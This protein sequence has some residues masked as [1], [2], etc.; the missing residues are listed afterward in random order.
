MRRFL[1]SLALCLVLATFGDASGSDR[2]VADAVSALRA[3][4]ATISDNRNWNGD[5]PDEG[6]RF[7]IF[8]P[9]PSAGASLEQA[10]DLLM[11]PGLQE[12]LYAIAV[13]AGTRTTLDIR[14][15]RAF[16][17]LE[18]LSISYTSVA[19]PED[20]SQLPNL[21][22]LRF[23]D[24]ADLDLAVVARA[25]QVTK[26]ELARMRIA[27]LAPL[28][29]MSG[30]RS[31]ELWSGQL[32]DW[33]SLGSLTQ[34]TALKLFMTGGNLDVL[35]GLRRLRSLELDTVYVGQSGALFRLPLERLS[36]HDSLAP[37]L[38]AILDM[39]TLR[40]IDLDT[41]TLPFAPAALCERLPALTEIRLREGIAVRDLND[42]APCRLRVLEVG[43]P[44]FTDLAPLARQTA[45]EELILGQPYASAR[46]RMTVQDIRPLANLVSLRD[47]RLRGADVSDFTP[48]AG[49]TNL[50]MLDISHTRASD[51]AFV[52]NLPRLRRLYVA[53]TSVSDL[54][55]LGACEYL[56]VLD[57]A[58]TQV[59][60]STPLAECSDLRRLVVSSG[61]IADFGP[62]ESLPLFSDM[63]GRR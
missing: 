56:Q 15:L 9:S 52:R 30:L 10:L 48:L 29:R 41:D 37:S 58:S 25:T 23:F 44:E 14:T 26:L 43:Q 53:G 62:I 34:V 49:L 18:R 54:T 17:R 57:V 45:L 4:G 13:G 61:L 63:V 21:R 59:R 28:Q 32:T 11:T 47:L 7:E 50:D 24:V 39:E 31:L 46:P 42:F 1:A 12:N 6:A 20:L 60:A 27:S 8:I 19:H 36:I 40:S 16:P 55:P 38:G 33:N 22:G 3:M 35:A 5:R 2:S 51:I